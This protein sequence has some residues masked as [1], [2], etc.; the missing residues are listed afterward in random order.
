[1]FPTL[2]IKYSIL[3]LPSRQL[4]IVCN[5]AMGSSF[6]SS[7]RSGVT[8]ARALALA[9]L[10]LVA[11][12]MMVPQVRSTGVASGL[13]VPAGCYRD[14]GEIGSHQKGAVDKDV[15]VSL[16]MHTSRPCACARVCV[17]VTACAYE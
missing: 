12:V 5:M 6:R 7:T 8:C 13:G 15:H 16:R 14:G 17:C 9:S 1:M 4:L 10:V 3:P 11:V 2:Y